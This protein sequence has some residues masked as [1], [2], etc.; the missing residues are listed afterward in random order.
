MVR[1]YSNRNIEYEYVHYVFHRI[2]KNK[3]ESSYKEKMNV[4]LIGLDSV[5]SSSFQRA[6]PKT[7][8]YLQSF[9]N[10]YHFKKYHS[11]GPSTPDTMVPFLSGKLKK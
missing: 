11:T 4:L 5:S 10:F 6:L 8:K 7:F 2:E 9:D 1:C 3:D